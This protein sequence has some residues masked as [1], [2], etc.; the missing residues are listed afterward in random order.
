MPDQVYTGSNREYVFM[1][2]KCPVSKWV[3]RIKFARRCGSGTILSTPAGIRRA[4][5]IVL[6]VI[7]F[8]SVLD[9]VLD[10]SGQPWSVTAGPQVR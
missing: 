10:G 5:Q 4:Q 8:S 6:K 2:P 1:I 3:A 7:M 9:P